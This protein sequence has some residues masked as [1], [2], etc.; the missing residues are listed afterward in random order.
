MTFQKLAYTQIK[1]DGFQKHVNKIAFRG[2][3]VFYCNE[4]TV[5]YETLDDPNKTTQLPID[6]GFTIA[7][8][9][10]NDTGSFLTVCGDSVVV[11]VL[12][13]APGVLA[14]ADNKLPRVKHWRI[15]L[16]AQRGE[17]VLKAVWNPVSRFDSELVVLTDANRIY[18]FDV[19]ANNN[20]APDQEITLQLSDADTSLYGQLEAVSF[21]FGKGEARFSLYVLAS[22]GN[23]YALAPFVPKTLVLTRFELEALFD[24]VV[25]AGIDNKDS[26]ENSIYQKQV[27]WVSELW[28]QYS[29]SIVESRVRSYGG[30]PEEFL[31]LNRPNISRTPIL[32]GPF[33]VQPFP[34]QLYELEGDDIDT[35]ELGPDLTGVGLFLQGG[36]FLLTLQE[37]PVVFNW[38]QNE[39]EMN[40]S[41]LEFIQ[42]PQNSCSISTS[43]CDPN[44]VYLQSVTNVQRLDLTAW[45][46]EL[47]KAIET[48]D[49]NLS[50][51]LTVINDLTDN[52]TP[53]IGYGVLID[54]EN[55]LVTLVQ[56]Q[57]H[58][59]RWLENWTEPNTQPVVSKIIPNLDETTQDNLSSYLINP[60]VERLLENQTEVLK[61]VMLRKQTPNAN[62]KI[63]EF[64]WDML[65]E[66]NEASKP[67]TAAV[68]QLHERQL[69]IHQR[70]VEQR[71][72]LERQLNK[73][74]ETKGKLAEVQT[75]NNVAKRVEETAE[76]QI[77]IQ[78]R[79]DK[80]RAGLLAKRGVQLL[81]QHEQAF[82]AELDRVK[83][84]LVVI[85]QRE[86]RVVTQSTILKNESQ[87]KRAPVTI[88]TG[89]GSV[90]QLLRIR[91]A[92]NREREVLDK[93]KMQVE[94]LQG[95]KVFA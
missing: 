77:K 73:I 86:A 88:P 95:D 55:S 83:A 63:K 85:T 70:L 37:E 22:D 11:I 38:T 15:D 59:I 78:E 72:E 75:R 62:I 40:L 39:L 74:T 6:L 90:E 30:E 64:T 32:Q 58:E 18:S 81:N 20:V 93:V 9:Q 16:F 66:F 4:Q 69:A 43:P 80:L 57:N 65:V 13:P 89:L 44:S 41:L 10:L 94:E 67:F 33:T 1:T 28:K 54:G 53:I 34:E 47:E 35:F 79:V 36:V 5:Y 21:C 68:P 61:P 31:V 17:A 76:R 71:S 42:T 29:Y 48:G 19:L 24:R 2:S 60:K 12:L 92:I 23:V 45:K 3:E 46:Q 49:A 14:V 84:S 25:L 87:L 50:Q 52:S 51:Q 7:S 91:Q 26:P 82:V 56:T 8:L 27:K